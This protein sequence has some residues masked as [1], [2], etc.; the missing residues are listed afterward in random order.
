MANRLGTALTS[1]QRDARKI[2]ARKFHSGAGKECMAIVDRL[3]FVC[4][5]NPIPALRVLSGFHPGRSVFPRR[6]NPAGF[7]PFGHGP[8]FQA[9]KSKMQFYV[10]SDR[11]EG[12]L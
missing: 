3:R 4:N 8:W 5:A 6:Q 11:R 9:E 12:W 1:K 10:E 7:R 2:I